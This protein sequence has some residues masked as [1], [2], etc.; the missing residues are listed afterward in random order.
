M[1]I[2]LLVLLT[3]C[4]MQH[5]AYDYNAEG[6]IIGSTPGSV[7]SGQVFLFDGRS[8]STNRHDQIFLNDGSSGYVNHHG[9]VIINGQHVG[10]VR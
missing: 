2:I 7:R 6:Q 4:A 1:W 3:G 10:T 5:T 8:G 9:Q